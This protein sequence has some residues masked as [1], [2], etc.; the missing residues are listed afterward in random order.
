[1]K[2]FALFS[3]VIVI[4]TT[5][6]SCEA[7]KDSKEP[8]DLVEWRRD[9]FSDK[10][11]IL[12][13]RKAKGDTVFFRFIENNPNINLFL[14]SGSM[15]TH[16][17]TVFMKVWKGKK[18]TPF[19]ILSCQEGDSIEMNQ[20]YS[21]KRIDFQGNERID[22]GTLSVKSVKRKDFQISNDHIHIFDLYN[23]FISSNFCR[24][25]Y[26]ENSYFLG[27]WFVFDGKNEFEGL[28][29][30]EDGLGWYPGGLI[31]SNKEL[32]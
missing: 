2:F 26:S 22:E 23:P 18:Y 21:A 5:Q 10:G 15:Y 27:V 31:L 8:K 3:L 7:S 28:D 25:V 9:I 11:D 20:P 32:K 13:M 12:K 6:M 19:L 4:S 1:M 16:L 24:I 14:D 17:D 29:V 30:I